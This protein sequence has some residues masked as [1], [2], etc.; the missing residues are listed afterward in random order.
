[1]VWQRLYQAYVKNTTKQE[2]EWIWLGLGAESSV[3]RREMVGWTK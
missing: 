1:M 2:K 3:M